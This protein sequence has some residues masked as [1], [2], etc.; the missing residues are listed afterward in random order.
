MDLLDIVVDDSIDTSV[1]DELCLANEMSIPDT[2]SVLDQLVDANATMEEQDMSELD[3]LYESLIEKVLEENES[4][5]PLLDSAPAEL[6]AQVHREMN[7]EDGGW[8]NQE[9][10]MAEAERRLG[11]LMHP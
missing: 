2:P 5:T 9:Y 10:G 4:S 11:L 7:S 1:L 8:H 3:K 6:V